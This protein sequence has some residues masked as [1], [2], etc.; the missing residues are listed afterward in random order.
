MKKIFIVLI[1]LFFSCSNNDENIENEIITYKKYV[2]SIYNPERPDLFGNINFEYSN[3]RLSKT[4]LGE[5]YTK[6]FYNDK[7]QLIRAED[8]YGR[9]VSYSYDSSDRIIKREEIGNNNF[10]E[11]KYEQGKITSKRY[12]EFSNEGKVTEIRESILDSKG[13]I[14]EI[15]DLSLRSG[16][17]NSPERDETRHGF[18]KYDYDENSNLIRITSKYEKNSEVRVL[19]L[20]YDDKINPYYVAYE[21]FN[22]SLY[23]IEFYIA[24]QPYNWYGL[25]PNNIIRIGSETIEYEYSEDNYPTQ[26]HRYY[27]NGLSSGDFYYNYN[28]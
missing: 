12:Y 13:R 16:D 3:N 21:S 23:Y 17:K 25:S 7:N 15:R 6:Y 4:F 19:E 14:I 22:K 27:G 26:F 20:K 18:E 5:N 28:E 1:T 24:V 9:G 2:K 8:N 10:I 11:L